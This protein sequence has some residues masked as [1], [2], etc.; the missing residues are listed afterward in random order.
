MKQRIIILAALAGACGVIMGAFGA[1]ALKDKLPETSLDIIRTGVLYLFVHTLAALLTTV[2]ADQSNYT[3]ALRF[4]GISFLT[5][6]AL[7]SGSLFIIST[8]PLTGIHS[9]LIGVMTPLGGL[10][11]IMGWLSFA[12][13]AW[14]RSS[15]NQG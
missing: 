15:V 2:I 13:W 5:G 12:W 7:F 11:F 8:S 3:G 9:T 1:H 10:F 14:R 4:T 6:V